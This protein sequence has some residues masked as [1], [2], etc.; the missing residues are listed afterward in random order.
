MSSSSNGSALL[1]VDDVILFPYSQMPNGQP[2]T[3]KGLVIGKNY[4]NGGMI[5]F[6]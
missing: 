6:M 4:Q 3:I 2:G 5:V 1:H